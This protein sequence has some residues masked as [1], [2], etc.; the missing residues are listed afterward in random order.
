LA[1]KLSE[2]LNYG[3]IIED[4]GSKNCILWSVT[5]L[6]ELR[7]IIDRINGNM[8]TP[9]VHRLEALID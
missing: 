8:R 3:N 1:K 7:D 5:S 6:K 2:I 9:K 4:K